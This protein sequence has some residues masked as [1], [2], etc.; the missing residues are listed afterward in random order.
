[1]TGKGTKQV[2]RVSIVGEEYAIRSE[3]TPEHTRAVASHVDDAIRR[4]IESGGTID[5]RKAAI[6]AALQITD[7][8]FE[9]RQAAENVAGSIR[10]LSNDVREWLV[11]AKSGDLGEG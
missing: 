10:A 8:L 4:I 11:Q 5:T 7:E 2:V 1:V 3:T 6:L 9:S